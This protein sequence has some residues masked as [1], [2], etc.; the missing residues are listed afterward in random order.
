MVKG[1]ALTKDIETDIAVVGGGGTGL[2]AAIA[3]A[4]KGARVAVLEKRR[5]FGGNAVM[6]E[7]LFATESDVQSRNFVDARSD[8]YFK[9]AMDYDHWK[10]NARLVR[11]FIDKSGDTIAW[12]EAKGI[13]MSL[14]AYYFNQLE[15]WHLFDEGGLKLIEVLTDNCRDLGV[16][17]FSRTSVKELL[18]NGKGKVA[19]VVAGVGKEKHAV[20]AKSVIIGTGGYGGNKK[21]LKKH[22][23][24][25]TDNMRCHGLPH[26]GDG[27]RM[28]LEAGAATEGLGI[29]QMGGP[30]FTGSRVLRV[31]GWE[32][33]N[34][35]VNKNGERFADE[36]SALKKFE[37]ANTLLQQPDRMCYV[38]FDE[39][40][41]RSI[42]ENGVI[43]G[44]GLIVSAQTKIPQIG[45]ELKVEASKGLLGIAGSWDGIAQWAGIKPQVLNATIDEYNSFCDKGHDDLFAKDRRYLMALRTPPYYALRCYPGFLTTIGGIKINHRME[46]V[47]RDY[48]YIPG[49]YAGGNDTGGWESDTYNVELSGAALGFAINSG[50][51][52]GENAAEYVLKK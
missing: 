49:L 13:T 17:L 33:Y 6:A 38:L 41:K 52:A 20:K 14:L 34:L 8:H 2:A 31:A 28:A 35:W 50:R 25:Y 16:Q 19:G 23:S 15:V 51:I 30:D 24:F 37:S 26:M 29:L 36:A 3:A 5:A 9:V 45:Q 48:N 7:G 11:A 12:L 10:L 27:L 40:I 21:L 39:S 18:I 46:V 44:T 47:D 4:E 22:C 1:I 32:P 43:I 42:E